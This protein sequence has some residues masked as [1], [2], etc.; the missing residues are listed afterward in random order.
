MKATESAYRKPL[1]NKVTVAKLSY[2]KEKQHRSD[3]S[4]I[5]TFW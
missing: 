1:L 2:S 3:Y 5:G 4:S